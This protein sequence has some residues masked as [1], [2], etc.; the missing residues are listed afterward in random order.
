MTYAIRGPTPPR[1]FD[2]PWHD[3]GGTGVVA[4]LLASHETSTLGHGLGTL[5]TGPDSEALAKRLQA[6][7]EHGQGPLPLEHQLRR[8]P[9]SRP[10]AQLRPGSRGVV[11][12]E[13]LE[14]GQ[15]A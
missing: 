7:L 11:L 9:I 10:C 15:Q 3:L 13:V 2:L 14:R 6:A 1:V 12:Q 5:G 8:E 4:V